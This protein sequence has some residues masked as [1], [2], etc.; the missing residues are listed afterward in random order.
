MRDGDCSAFKVVS[1]QLQIGL[2]WCRV[3]VCQYDT[4]GTYRIEI[5]PHIGLDEKESKTVTLLQ[6]LDVI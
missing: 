5:R 6:R 4:L 2:S 3:S 1:V